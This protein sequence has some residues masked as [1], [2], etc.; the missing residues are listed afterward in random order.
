MTKAF[1]MEMAPFQLA[2]GVTEET[3]LAASERLDR[4]FLSQQKGYIGRALTQLPDASWAD[5][6]IWESK[7]AA[8]AIMPLVS[9]S[10]AAGAYFSCMASADVEDPAHGITLMIAHRV[11]GALSELRALAPKR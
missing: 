2:S 8:E 6:V 1:T 5:L 4:E 3:L 9:E 7:A 11:Y 10:P